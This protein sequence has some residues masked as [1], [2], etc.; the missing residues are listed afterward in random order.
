MSSS[1]SLS[2]SSEPAA[3]IAAPMAWVMDVPCPIDFVLGSTA[4]RVR[5]CVQFV[6]NAV[7][8][9]RQAAGA[10]LEVRVNGVAI[11]TGEV[12]ISD[13]SV[14]IRLNRIL[15]PVGVEAA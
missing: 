9:L 4:V 10:D 11:A 12:V 1:P 15:P 3:A 7:V 8:R 13:E 6:P 5:E 14:G 2:S